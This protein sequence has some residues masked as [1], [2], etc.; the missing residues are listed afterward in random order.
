MQIADGQV[1]LKTDGEAMFYPVDNKTTG[2]SNVQGPVEDKPHKIFN[3][4]GQQLGKL[5]R[6]VNIV[7]GKK[8][9]VR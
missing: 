8:V 3:L 2:I 9:I 6:R 1:Y 4:S 5:Q 7:D